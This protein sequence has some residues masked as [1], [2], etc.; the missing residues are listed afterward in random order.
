MLRSALLRYASLRS[1]ELSFARL[2]CAKLRWEILENC[3]VS[4]LENRPYLRTGSRFYAVL[5][6]AALGLA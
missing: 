1:A 3:F 4:F 6:S 2:C 5:S